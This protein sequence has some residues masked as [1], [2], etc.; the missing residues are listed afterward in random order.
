[1]TVHFGAPFLKFF[2]CSDYSVV[3]IYHP[4]NISISRV[5]RC[6]WTGPSIP[7]LAHGICC[8]SGNLFRLC[9]ILVRIGRNLNGRIHGILVVFQ[10]ICRSCVVQLPKSR[11]RKCWRTSIG[12]G[13]SVLALGGYGLFYDSEYFVEHIIHYCSPPHISYGTHLACMDK[14]LRAVP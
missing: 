1:M 9:D 14:I 6:E 3:S 4:V 8:Q 10:I 11:I 2:S 5:Y 7:P 13:S 12:G